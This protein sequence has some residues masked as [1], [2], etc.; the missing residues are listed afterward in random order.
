MFNNLCTRIIVVGVVVVF[1]WAG[2]NGTLTAQ[3]IENVMMFVAGAIFGRG[4]QPVE[5]KDKQP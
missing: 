3:T 1:V 4:R 5:L 2:L